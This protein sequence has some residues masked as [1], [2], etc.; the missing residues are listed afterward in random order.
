MK[1]KTYNRI[2]TILKII[3]LISV[4]IILFVY[5]KVIFALSDADYCRR[6]VNV[7]E[8]CKNYDTK[9]TK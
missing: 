7:E 9:S 1:K 8:N 6:G 5:L 3:G 2:D 4:A